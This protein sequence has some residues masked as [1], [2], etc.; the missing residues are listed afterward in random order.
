MCLYT[1][2]GKP[3]VSD[4]ETECWKI[5]AVVRHCKTGIVWRTSPHTDYIIPDAAV[6][7]LLPMESGDPYVFDVWRK[8]IEETHEVGRGFIHS[9]AGKIC[10]EIK[11]KTEYERWFELLAK[12]DYKYQIEIENCQ[13]GE[14]SKVELLGYELRRCVIPAGEYFYTGLVNPNG[15]DGSLGYASRKIEIKEV[16]KYIV[17]KKSGQ[18]RPSNLEG[19]M[20]MGGVIPIPGVRR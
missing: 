3:E 17:P 9:Y 2:S 1:K 11:L 4:N 5:F 10:A 16:E 8:Q 18:E 12:C 7:G 19:I 6:R 13:P 20:G 15:N 14:D